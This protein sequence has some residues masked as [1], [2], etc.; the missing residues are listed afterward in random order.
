MENNR[1]CTESREKQREN[2]Y[3]IKQLREYLGI[4][5]RSFAIR[6]GYSMTQIGRYEEGITIPSEEVIQKI[7]SEYGVDTNYFKGKKKL[8]ESAQKD[9][10][11]KGIAARIIKSRTEKGWTQ[12]KLAEKS[13]V[14]TAIISRVESGAKLTEK[15]GIKLAEALGVG[16]EWL[17]K[18]N[19]K[20]KQWP[21]DK[22]MIDWLWEHDDIRREL[23][24][25]MENEEDLNK[26]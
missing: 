15:Q 17:M 3:R 10:S 23:W 13:G 22:K 26:G 8:E 2:G 12:K 21:A 11:E 18:G 9:E 14:N 25:Q 6:L 5:R 1:K 4:S 16:I 19:E 7:C 24:N 20:K